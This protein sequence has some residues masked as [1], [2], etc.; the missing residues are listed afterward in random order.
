[1]RKLAILLAVLLAAAS[2]PALAAKEPVN[3]TP[4][5]PDYSSRSLL[6]LMSR[7]NELESDFYAPGPRELRIPRF[8]TIGFL[9]FAPFVG[10]AGSSASPMPTVDPFVLASVP[11]AYTPKT[12]RDRW[13]EWRLRRKLGENP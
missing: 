13:A 2:L 4:A 5:P 12:Y 10:V 7:G 11:A 6:Y 1:M 8:G 9:L 3:T